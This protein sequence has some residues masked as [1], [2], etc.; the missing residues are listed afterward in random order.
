MA[1]AGMLFLAL[2]L[3]PAQRAQAQAQRV[4]AVVGD[5]PV[6]DYD[7]AQRLKLNDV[8]GVRATGG[9]AQLHKEILED[10]I[11]EVIKDI[12]AK[13]NNVA[14]TEKQ[15]AEA[16]ERMAKSTGSTREDLEARLKAK[17]ISMRTLEGQVAS[18]IGFNWLLSRKYNVDVKVD[19]AEVD[20]RFASFSSDPRLKPVSVYELLEISLP[21]EATSEANAEQVIYARAIEAR[22]IMQRFKGCAS[23]RQAASGIYNVKISK[24]IQAP[25]DQMPAPMREVLDEKGPG[26]IVGPMRSKEGI[27]VIAYCRRASLAPPKPTREVVENMLLNEKYKTASSRIL[28]DLRRSVFID[29][30]VKD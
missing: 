24:T 5:R 3:P 1:I 29:Y 7:V 27:Q 20:R 21:V 8:L 2:G 11:D 12:E 22:Q 19:P 18:T 28:R 14:P 23:V 25:V 26:S 6:T 16:I 4:L 17:G 13:K 30:K 10:L 9:V 15:V